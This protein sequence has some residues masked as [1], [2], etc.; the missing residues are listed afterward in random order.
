[1]SAGP[2]VVAIGGG[3][4]LAATL[5]AARRYAGHVTGI[6]ATADDSGST[7]RLRDAMAIPA[8]GDLRRCLEALAGVEDRPL[9]RAMEHRFAG[10]DLAGHT[11]G[12]LLLAGL[13]AV[14]GDFIEATEEVSRLIGLDPDRARVIP[15]TVEPVTL[16]CTTV[17]GRRVR[18]QYA[19]SKTTGIAQVML[20]PPRVKAPNGVVDAIYRADQV[21]LGPGSVYTSVL[22]AALVPDVRAA[23]AATAARR[24]YVCN[25]EPEPGE[26]GGYDVAAHVAALRRH[27]IEPDVVLIQDDDRLALGDVGVDVVRADLAVT[28]EAAH[29]SWKLAVALAAIVA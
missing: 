26:T 13:S 22:A 9:G 21:V 25:I 18:G 4:G 3:R 5:R 17:D 29:D 2:D 7:G 6:V 11:L 8:P 12:N 20:D 24:V 1:V 19:V 14:T 27:G 15:A 23:L 16:H 28:G 10:T